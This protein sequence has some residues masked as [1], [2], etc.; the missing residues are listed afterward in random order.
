MKKTILIIAFWICIATALGSLL[1]MI[2]Q[3]LTHIDQ[4]KTRIFV[5]NWRVVVIM[6]ASCIGIGFTS[7]RFK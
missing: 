6:T 7:K 1:Y 2:Y 4:T 3:Q 5:D